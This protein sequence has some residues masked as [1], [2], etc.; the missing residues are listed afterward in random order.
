MNI[1][2]TE[3]QFEKNPLAFPDNKNFFVIVGSNNSGKSTLLRAINKTYEP[4]SYLVSV[5]RTILKGEGPLDKNYQN[6]YRGYTAGLRRAEDDN[7]EKSIYALQDFFN[8]KNLQREPIVNWYNNYF[9]NQ[10]IEEREDPENDASP[11]FLKVNGHSI[12]KQGSGMRSVLE[13]FVKLFDPTIKI[14]CIDEPELGL[15]PILQ[16]YL[17]RAIKD[18][19]SND[20]KIFISTHSHHFLDREEENNYVCKRNSAGKI[21]IDQTNDLKEIIFRLLGNTLSGFLLPEK[22]VIVEGGSDD[23]YLS[24]CLKL[25]GKTDCSAHNSGGGQ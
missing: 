14:L 21:Y 13:I 4:D 10:M 15:E 23:I 2:D 11:M 16:K 18:K 22:I 24:G 8:L 9:P 19:A 20:K 12:T 5:N 6:N 17:F 7:F 3:K 25:L 1:T